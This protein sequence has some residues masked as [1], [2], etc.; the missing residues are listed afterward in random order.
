MAHRLI[1]SA[2][3][4]SLLL[5]S[6]V[7]GLTAGARTVHAADLPVAPP[8]V[9][10]VHGWAGCYVGVNAG[11]M[12]GADRIT[13]RPGPG[14]S[15]G[16][17]SGLPPADAALLTSTYSSN[18]SA[19][20]TGGGQTGCNWQR[21]GSPLVIGAELD[22]NGARLRE[23]VTAAYAPVTLPVTG[24]DIP[25]RI[26]VV[27]KRLDWYSTI[28]GRLGLGWDRWLAYVTGG[29]A[30]THI[31]S[32]L[33]I[34]VAPFA[35]SDSR[36]RYGWTAGGGV[37]YAFASKWTVRL[38]YLFLDFGAYTYVAPHTIAN[39]RFWSADVDAREHVLRAG[40]NYR[41]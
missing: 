5:S 35:G 7:L 34:P 16:P 33:D 18:Q 30:I 37:E 11:W 19:G 20:F 6:G 13:T 15:L 28:R 25:G 4:A 9:A 29:L 8:V 41:F 38:E 14:G 27:T 32:S 23:S 2:I 36:T 17:L 26:E 12:G 24:I 1:R 22:F 21:A 10:T 40:L 3:A 31:R 39:A